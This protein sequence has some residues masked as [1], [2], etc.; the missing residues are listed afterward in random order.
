MGDGGGVGGA[1]KGK[2]FGKVEKRGKISQNANFF[3]KF[4][5]FVQNVIFI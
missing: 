1:G 3:L 5:V 2:I 4:V